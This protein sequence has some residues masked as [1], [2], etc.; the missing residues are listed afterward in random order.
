MCHRLLRSMARMNSGITAKSY[1]DGDTWRRL[2]FSISVLSCT[3]ATS[4]YLRLN[5]S[6]RWIFTLCCKVRAAVGISDDPSS[7]YQRHIKESLAPLERIL[8]ACRHDG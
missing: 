1:R 3:V 5:E 2:R 7:S 8:G 4:G 6:G